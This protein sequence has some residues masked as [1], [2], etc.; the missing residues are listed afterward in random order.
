MLPQYSWPIRRI[1][2]IIDQTT[3]CTIATSLF[4]SKI[5]YYNSLL[6]NLPTT[7]TNRLQLVLNSAARIVTKTPKFHHI[8][9]ILKSLNWLKMRESNTRF[10]L[11]HI[12][13]SKLVN[14]LTSA[15]FFHFLHIDVLGLPLLSPF[16]RPSLTSRLN[17]ANRP[18]SFYHSAPVSWSNLPSHLRQVVHHVT[19]S[20]PNS[21]VSDLST[22]L[23]LKKLKTHLFHCS[24]PP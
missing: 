24:F 3:A 21:L 20:I 2:N 14:L 22:S 18:K 8:T 5:D 17:I 16:S 13:L 4:H 6:L 11:S 7:Q 12:N 10:S 1:R 9:S 19:P 23:F 15:L